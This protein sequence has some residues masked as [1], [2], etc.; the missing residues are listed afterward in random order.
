MAR[1]KRVAK[2]KEKKNVPVGLVHIQASFN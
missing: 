1:P 2:K